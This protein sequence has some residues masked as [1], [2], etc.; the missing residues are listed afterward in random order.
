MVGAFPPTEA[1]GDEVEEV[2]GI[3]EFE[4]GKLACK[5]AK[6]VGRGGCHATGESQPDTRFARRGGQAVMIVPTCSPSKA[7]ARLPNFNPLMTW[8]ERWCRAFFI[9]VGTLCSTRSSRHIASNS[10]TVIDGMNLAFGSFLG[11]AA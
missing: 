3:K 6:V 8:I 7:R 10:S 1:R 2:K 5:M 4:V 11:S 9:N